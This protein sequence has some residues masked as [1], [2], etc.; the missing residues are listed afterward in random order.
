M[1]SRTSC[2]FAGFFLA[3]LMDYAKIH[4]TVRLLL[5]SQSFYDRA[6]FRTK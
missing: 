3:K 6:K 4:A 5:H 1:G 2:R